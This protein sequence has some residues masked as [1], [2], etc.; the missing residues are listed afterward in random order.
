MVARGELELEIESDTAP[1]GLLARDMLD[2]AA[3]SSR[4]DA[5]HCLRDPTR[6]VVATTLNEIAL[7]SEVCIELHEDRIPVREEVK[8]AREIPGL[9]PLYVA[10]EG[11]LIA[12]VPA[13]IAEPAGCAHEREHVRPRCLHHRRGE[14]GGAGNRCSEDRLWRDAHREYARRRAVARNML[15]LERLSVKARCLF[16]KIKD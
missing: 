5:I 13:D 11:K 12:T 8:G 6:V 3:L 4:V 1:L 14:E 9:D 16:L 10:S 7:S 2:E 15:V